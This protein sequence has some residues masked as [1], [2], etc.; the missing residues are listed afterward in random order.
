MFISAPQGSK[1]P[2]HHVIILAL[3]IRS[4]AVSGGAFRTGVL[5]CSDEYGNSVLPE[6]NP[7]D[8]TNN[9]GIFTFPS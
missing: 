9:N 1:I 5:A 4:K 6:K 8:Q 3:P 2:V 7:L